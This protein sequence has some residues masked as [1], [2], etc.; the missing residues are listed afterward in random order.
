M[1]EIIWFVG[2]VATTLLATVEHFQKTVWR[3]P[4]K[5]TAASAFVVLG[6]LGQHQ[7][8]SQ[9]LLMLGLVFGFIGDFALLSQ[10]KKP[11]LLGIGAFLIGHALYAAAWYPSAELST[12]MEI[13][14]LLF[15]ALALGF[16]PYIIRFAEGFMKRA[17]VAY[18]LV[19]TIM[20]I[21]ATAQSQVSG[22]YRYVLGAAMFAL[23]DVSVALDRFTPFP[24][25]HRWLGIP[26]YFV[27]QYI[28]A[29]T[30]L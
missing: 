6:L 12:L 20:G 2:L 25:W 14:S 28:L 10:D 17:V 1:V 5:M 4:L 24:R 21:T 29:S 11:F 8:L 15:I 9:Q 19:I 13:P 22:D 23:S 18:I 7:T 3:A 16:T 27:S 26:L 30:L